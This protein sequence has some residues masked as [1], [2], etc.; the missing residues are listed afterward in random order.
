[1]TTYDN[2]TRASEL[3]NAIVKELNRENI[4]HE[5]Y[6]PENGFGILAEGN[7]SG[8]FEITVMS[9]AELKAYSNAEKADMQGYG[10]AFCNDLD[11][12]LDYARSYFWVESV[13]SGE[14][15]TGRV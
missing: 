15:S 12:I 5:A 1:M 2:I 4:L 14:H 8:E 9:P 10:W 3:F 7:G 6:V 11:D 13:L